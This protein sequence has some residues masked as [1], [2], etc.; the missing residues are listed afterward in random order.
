MK[1][2][3]W[4]VAM[5]V[6][7]VLGVIGAQWLAQQEQS[8]LGQVIVRTGGYD[9]STTL[10]RAMLLLVLAWLA[11]GF[12]WSLLRLPFRAWGRYRERQGRARLIE[13]LRALQ[14]GHWL[15]AERLLAGAVDDPEVGAIAAAAAVRA[16]DGRG[17]EAAAQAWLTA[18]AARDPAAHAML[19]AERLLERGLPVDAI[20]ALDVATAQPL[21]PRGLLLR[22]RAL[23]AIGR[24]GEAYGLLG[25]L[26]QQAALPEADLARLEME[27]ATGSLREAA[28]ANLL[29]EY[30]EA[31]PKP[32]RTE[33][34]V[35]AAYAERAAALRW[36]EAALRHLE[37]ALDARWDE[38][39][40]DLYGRLAIG[41][42]DSRRA[43]A[44]RWLQA[45]PASPALLVTLARLARKQGQ[46]LQAQDFLHRALAQGAGAD[47]WEE[48]GA[49]FA[50]AGDEALA[51]RAYANALHAARG[52]AAEELPGRDLREKI[53]DRAVVEDRDEHGIPRLKE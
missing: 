8:G 51:R 11:L 35:V 7:A 34:V 17:D 50:A 10:P 39:L 29:A 12:L 44:Q 15:R 38:S 42:V 18:L 45:H 30:W 43:S 16:A 13:G 5:L 23:Q 48:M 2:Y 1:P 28:D 46:W 9:Y 49:G 20:N 41:H 27:L 36:D 40:A 19:S 47:A 37:Q 22:V 52:E 33:P 21:P 4:L 3:R 6:V 14:G 53:Y 31:M 32:L 26:R 25:A 24:A